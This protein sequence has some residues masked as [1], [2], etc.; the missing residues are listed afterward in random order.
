LTPERSRCFLGVD[1]GRRR[2]GLALCDPE[3]RLAYPLATLQARGLDDLAAR[4]AERVAE[5]AASAV[6]LGSPRRLD[7]SPGEIV[8]DVEDLAARL[9]ARGIAVILWDE[10]LT[11]WEAEEKLRH[12]PIAVRRRKGA[13]DEAAAT[14]L[15]Q[16]YIETLPR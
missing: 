3:G 16:S 1:Y 8:T 2:T 10:R 14:I 9:R 5:H 4:L 6:V 15:L 12:A 7:G 11:T 13:A